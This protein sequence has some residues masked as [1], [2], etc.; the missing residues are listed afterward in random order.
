MT[1]LFLWR[2]C[3]SSDRK[4]LGVQGSAP[5]LQSKMSGGMF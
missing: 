4:Y 1:L 2:P 3:S 5:V